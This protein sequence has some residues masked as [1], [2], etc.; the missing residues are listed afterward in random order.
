MDIK[1]VMSKINKEFGEEQIVRL[2]VY[3]DGSGHIASYDL[4]KEKEIEK[5]IR[6]YKWDELESYISSIK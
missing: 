5:L 2:V 1:D 6:F 3:F 4:Y